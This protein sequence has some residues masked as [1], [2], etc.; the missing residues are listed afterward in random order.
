LLKVVLWFPSSVSAANTY[1]GVMSGGIAGF[2]QCV[3]TNPM[4]VTKMFYQATTSTSRAAL[5]E[6]TAVLADLEHQ[7]PEHTC[8]RNQRC[9]EE[10]PRWSSGIVSR[11]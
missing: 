2:T 3:A 10:S 6:L 7:T 8:S 1:A 4:E 11:C 9:C 5:P